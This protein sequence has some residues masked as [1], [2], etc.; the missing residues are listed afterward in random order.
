MPLLPPFKVNVLEPLPSIVL[1]NV[2][3]APVGVPLPFVESKV[4]LAPTVTGPVIPIAPPLLVRFPSR[5]ID[6]PV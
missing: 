6:V 4:R 5:R 1:E 2:I 3:F